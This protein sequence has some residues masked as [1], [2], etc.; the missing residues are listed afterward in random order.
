MCFSTLISHWDKSQQAGAISEAVTNHNFC[1]SR[2]KCRPTARTCDHEQERH[3]LSCPLS[4]FPSL[5]TQHTDTLNYSNSTLEGST[6]IYYEPSYHFLK[7]LMACTAAWTWTLFLFNKCLLLPKS[8]ELQTFK[9]ADIGF[10]WKNKI[11]W[12]CRFTEQNESNERRH[13]HKKL[14]C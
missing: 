1:D 8:N 11:G 14:H 13:I 5:Q 6:W 2:H 7:P 3:H 12:S 4:L 10:V 9:Q